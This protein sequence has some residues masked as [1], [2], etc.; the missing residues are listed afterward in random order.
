MDG[1]YAPGGAGR[2]VVLDEHWTC[3]SALAVQDVLGHAAGMEVCEAYLATKASSTPDADSRIRPHAGAAG[4]LAEAVV[5]G[6]VLNPDG[7]HTERALAYGEWFLRNTYQAADAPL[8]PNPRNLIG[9]FRDTPYRLDVR[10]DA[11]Q[12]IGCALLGVEA[13]LSST[14]PGSLP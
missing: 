7:P 11:V 6:A 3:L 14:Q 5:A 1:H 2:L 10:M 13:L 4:G 9:G 12:H 8:L